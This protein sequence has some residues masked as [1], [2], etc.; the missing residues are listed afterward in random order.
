MTWASQPVPTKAL[1]AM[2]A[3]SALNERLNL[4][5]AGEA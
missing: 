2:V 4:Q 3:M 1:I 5:E